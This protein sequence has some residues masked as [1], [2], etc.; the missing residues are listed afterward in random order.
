MP[1]EERVNPQVASRDVEV[2]GGVTTMADLSMAP[3][4]PEVEVDQITERKPAQHKGVPMVVIR[5]NEDIEEM[6]WVAAGRSERYNF[7]AGHRYR[8]PVYI[9]QELENLGKLWH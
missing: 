9:A 7:Q 3:K 1:T 6:S 4:L 8:V 5:V 2:D